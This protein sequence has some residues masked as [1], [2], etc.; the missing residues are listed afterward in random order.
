MKDV[1]E[2]IGIMQTVLE[3]ACETAER[4]DRLGDLMAITMTV[5]DEWAMKHNVSP[6]ELEDEMVRC[7]EIMRRCHES[8]G[9]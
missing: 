1:M 4:I 5:L 9:W 8:L 2:R 3:S 7:I 6:K